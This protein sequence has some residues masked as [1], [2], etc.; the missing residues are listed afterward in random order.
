MCLVVSGRY[1]ETVRGDTT[2][3]G[4]GH[5][6]FC[7]AEEP[8]SQRFSREGASKITIELS[9]PAIDLLAEKHALTP[10]GYLMS[11]RVSALARQ[12]SDE[13]TQQDDCAA[14]VVEGLVLEA[15]GLFV[16]SR[17]APGDA[18]AWLE[19]VRE[20][21]HANSWQALTLEDAARV[22]ERH[23]A[24]LAREFKRTYGV[25]VGHY[26]KE[27]RVA[28]AEMLLAKD[29]DSLAEIA[30]ICGFCDQ[31]HMTR[32][33]RRARGITPA[34]YRQIKHQPRPRR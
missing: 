6:L 15:I 1:E 29:V 31:A 12:L 22:A 21:L 5:L 20:Y 30:D 34:R 25:T 4:E 17:S 23:P 14:M 3:H 13:L 26:A 24:H 16:R 32:V 10:G 33:F 9:Q 19:K 8:H 7:A 28:R 27:L 11:P 2:T 18:T